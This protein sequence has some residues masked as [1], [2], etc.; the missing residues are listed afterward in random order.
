MPMEY[1]KERLQKYLARCGVGSRRRCE[2]IIA[3]GRVK[4]NHSIQGLGC[5]VG[6]EDLVEVDGI[7]VRPMRFEYYVVNKPVGYVCSNV[8]ERGRKRA[9]DLI[10]SAVEKGLFTAGR[11]DVNTSGIVVVTN[12]G[13]F[14]N[15]LVH[16]SRG[17]EKEYEMLVRGAFGNEEKKEMSQGV[18]I[19][20][21]RLAHAVVSRIVSDGENTLVWIIIHEG[22]FRIV[23][24]MMKALGKDLLSLKRVRVGPIELGDL[25]EGRYRLLDPETAL[26]LSE[27]CSQ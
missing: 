10:P 8:S 14:A 18:D 20:E 11:L 25:E 5:K 1:K 23:R 9:I 24:R 2:E 27:T 12:D 13:D 6:P 7:P 15:H 3:N 16:P 19:G 26:S 22:R 21:Q 4:V 17:V